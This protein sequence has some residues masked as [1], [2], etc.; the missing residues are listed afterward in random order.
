MI[1]SD[2]HT[3][4]SS[5]ETME[6]DEQITVRVTCEDQDEVFLEVNANALIHEAVQEAIGISMTC[7]VNQMRKTTHRMTD[8]AGHK[9]RTLL[10]YF[11]EEPIDDEASFLDMG[12]EDGA[13]LH[14]SAIRDGIQFYPN[15]LMGK[16]DGGG[17]V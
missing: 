7:R 14:A 16:A 11:G 2:E 9:I 10:V 8:S 3:I 12:M 15:L 6:C 13:R 4:E 5:D 17:K 1:T